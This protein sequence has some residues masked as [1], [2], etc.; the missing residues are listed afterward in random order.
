MFITRR[1]QRSKITAAFLI[2]VFLASVI[3]N[4]AG[5]KEMK[6]EEKLAALVGDH[7]LTS[8]QRET[9]LVELT[10][11][12]YIEGKQQGQTISKKNLQTAR[13]EVKDKIKNKINSPTIKREYDHVFSGFSLEL[14]GNDIPDLLTVEGVKA[15]YPS[16]EY[17]V[18]VQAPLSI[19]KQKEFHPQMND[20]APY[21]GAPEAWEQG[22]TGQ[23]IT[24]AVI[25]TGVDYTH[26]DLEHAF[27]D[28]KGYDFVDDDGDPQETPPGE[29]EDVETNHGTHVAGTI[30]ANG[31]M[32]GI[33]PDAN[34][35]GYRVL[36]PGGSGTTEDVIAGIEQAVEDGADVMNLSLGN[37]LNDAD[38]ATSIALDWAMAEGVAAV[39]SNG[40]AGDANW[41]VG[42]P[43]TSRDAIS[44]G[45]SQLPYNLFE[46]ELLLDSTSFSSAEV[47]G[48]PAEEDLLALQDESRELVFAGLGSKEEFEAIHAEGKI[49]LMV[50]GELAFVDKAANAKEAGA[51]GAIIYNNESGPIPFYIPGMEV[52][53]WKLDDEDGQK[54]AEAVRS[55]NTD[56]SITLEPAGEIGETIADFSSRGP[57]FGTWMIKPDVS[58]PG[59]DITSTVPTH[60]EEDPHG[61]A[62][63]QGTSMAA[64]HAAGAA[65]LILQ[66]NPD[67]MVEDVKG[68]LMNTAESLT[69]PEGE[70][71]PHNTQGSGSIRISEALNQTT[72]AVPG[73]HS[74]GT[75]LKDK[76]KQSERQHIT[77][78]NNSNTTKDYNVDVSFKGDQKGISVS[79][80]NN[81]K[82]AAGNSKK[83]N[84]N[85]KVDAAK[86]EEGHHEGLISLSHA[87]ETIEIPTIF[88]VKEPD[89]PRVTHFSFQQEE[90]GS[91]QMEMYTPGGAD[92]AE[93][94]L[95]KG[96]E[97]EYQGIAAE[98][99]NLEPGYNTLTWNGLLNNE[100]L[101]PGT[102]HLFAFA[103]KNNQVDY[104]YGGEFTIEE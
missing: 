42:S 80:S 83:I 101:N 64:P 50:R 85:V 69:D 99:S 104:V 2:F 56:L 1:R 76:G 7:N 16:V 11:P 8:N 15:V 36:G 63:M 51:D 27:G 46:T 35:L 55:G 34:L 95:Y 39:T 58:A 31:K 87:D 67:W 75:F 65:A 86:L 102:Y 17:E 59:V 18:D 68:T 81:T 22:L 100:K 6:D 88:F 48:F 57:A 40:N 91:F 93:I 13:S 47:M 33:A 77:V 89:Y 71:Y 29:E 37:I 90:D 12:G 82:I 72:I 78:K 20:S 92:T 84:L 44:V 96:D 53:T 25:D 30:A 52:P 103:Q 10:E 74:F 19:L 41:T 54:L 3:F 32:K 24:V 9:V 98:G 14:K 45:A 73:S 23:G 79:T 60:D 97:L 70:V 38:Y 4:G 61:Y 5:A 26:P 43:G 62:S 21:V 94:A 49:A 66:K 28:Y